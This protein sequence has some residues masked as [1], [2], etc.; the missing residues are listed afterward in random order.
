MDNFKDVSGFYVITVSVLVAAAAA[1][2]AAAVSHQDASEP[3][4]TTVWVQ[5]SYMI[6]SEGY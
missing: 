4:K 1:G 6:N 5:Q 3:F 2:A